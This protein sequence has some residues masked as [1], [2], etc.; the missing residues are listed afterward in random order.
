MSIGS[1]MF[2]EIKDSTE[3]TFYDISSIHCLPNHKGH[4]SDF[5]KDI[6]IHEDTL[7]IIQGPI[8]YR[9]TRAQE[10]PELCTASL[11]TQKKEDPLYNFEVFAE[12]VKEHYAYLKLNDI[13]WPELYKKQKSK[14]KQTSTQAE[15]FLVIEETL[16]ILNDNHRFLEANEEVYEQLDALETEEEEEEADGTELPELGDFPVARLVSKHH[17]K[18]EMTEDSWLLE[19]GKMTDQIGFIQV[20]AMWLYGDLDLPKQLVDD[21]GHVDAYIKVFN[22]MYESN[23]LKKELKGVNKIMDK[24]MK[25]LADMEAIVIDLRFNGGGQDA[26]SYEILSRFS[27]KTIKAAEQK[28]RYGHQF[29]KVHP[30]YIKGRKDAFTKPVYLLTSPETGSAAEGFALASMKLDHFK[31][32]GSSTMG[33][34][35]TSLGKTLP[36]D[37]VFAISNEI[38]MDLDGNVYENKGVPVDHEMNYSRDRQTFFRSVADDL[39]KDKE[40][41]LMAISKLKLE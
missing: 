11:S 29:T 4:F 34:L 30:S 18:E 25:D 33:A 23:Y 21:L 31:R 17:M 36:N 20:K 8:N 2:L 14:L 22:E 3:Y 32:I 40:D 5:K 19:W 35:S 13:N 6:S 37:W 27:Y 7:S 26:V 24:V 41:I 38:V 10:L 16:E 1:G 28:F 9:F 15:L 12:T 39:S